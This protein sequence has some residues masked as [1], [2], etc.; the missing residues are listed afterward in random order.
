VKIE[1]DSGDVDGVD[2]FNYL[3]ELCVI[4]PMSG[5]PMKYTLVL[6]VDREN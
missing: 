3:I 2:T 5:V 1:I 6:D 4:E